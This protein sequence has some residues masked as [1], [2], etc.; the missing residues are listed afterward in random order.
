MAP[1]ATEII[2]LEQ[3]RR[4]FRP[5]THFRNGKLYLFD[6]HGV[7]VVRPWP[8]PAAWRRTRTKPWR[9]RRP[10]IH[11][12]GSHEPVQM[13]QWNPEDRAW[14]AFEEAIPVHVRDVI[15]RFPDRHFHLLSLIARCPGALDLASN[16]PALAYALASNWVFHRPG[17]QRPLRSA[18][19]LLR[20]RQTDILH[21]LGFPPTRAA[22]N[23]LRKLTFEATTVDRLLYLRSCLFDPRC[24]KLLSHLPS[25]GP[26]T[27]RVVSD[28]FL[29]SALAPSALDELA[30]SDRGKRGWELAYQLRDTLRVAEMLPDP[31]TLRFPTLQ[32][33][34]A[35]HD[36]L[37]DRFNEGADRWLADRE[38]G[39]L[40]SFGPPPLPGTDDLVPLDDERKLVEEGQ[41]M[42]H[43]IASYASDVETGDAYVYR[44]LRPQRAT[45]LLR[46]DDGDWCVAEALGPRNRQIS[47]EAWEVL[48]RWMDQAEELAWLKVYVE[49][50]RESHG[51]PVEPARV[52][53]M[54]LA[55][56]SRP[57]AAP[58]R[59]P[60]LAYF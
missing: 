54:G 10:R 4:P 37:V 23:I 38:S 46:R 15:A 52:E 45:V 39:D 17:V 7:T 29:R 5:G 16:T 30:R 25:I 18:R 13:A 59:A 21:W 44:L 34:F 14:Q 58:G 3:S 9:G 53:Q 48:E 26:G 20:R 43:C 41:Q 47:T 32:R 57:G 35:T 11:L 24:C 22:R 2:T 49:G 56:A 1:G 50:L 31:P 36:D 40:R 33:L 42:K 19:T 8:R 55:L 51:S 6:H 60:D 27:V 28:D 12:R